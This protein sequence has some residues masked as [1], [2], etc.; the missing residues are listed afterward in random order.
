MAGL[1]QRPGALAL[2]P[3]VLAPRPAVLVWRPALV[4]RRPAFLPL[5][6]HRADQAVDDEAVLP[7]C[8]VYGAVRDEPELLAECRSFRGWSRASRTSAD[9]R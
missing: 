1:G 5:Q 3:A 4:P 6:E 9:H 2:S 7:M 8:R